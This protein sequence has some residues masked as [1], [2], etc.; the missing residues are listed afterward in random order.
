[1]KKTVGSI[2]LLKP[3]EWL[4]R[5]VEVAIE[6]ILPLKTI[7]AAI[8]TAKYRQVFTSIREVGDPSEHLVVCRHRKFQEKFALWTGTCAWMC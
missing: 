2:L 5:V 6:D 7:K 1:M 3:L 4:L 8:K